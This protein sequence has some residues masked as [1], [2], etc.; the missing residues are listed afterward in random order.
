MNSQFFMGCDNIGLMDRLGRLV[1][2]FVLIVIAIMGNPI[3]W[4]GFV[5]LLTAFIG[6]CPLYKMVGLNTG[7]QKAE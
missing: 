7:C 2:G 5:P 4:I 3:G 1:L 6:M